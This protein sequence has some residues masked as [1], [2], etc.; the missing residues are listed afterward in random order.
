MHVI[1]HGGTTVFF[2]SGPV[3]PSHVL[4]HN[5]APPPLRDGVHSTLNVGELVSAS[6]DL[7]GRSDAVCEVSGYLLSLSSLHHDRDHVER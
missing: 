4:F 5:G 7:C 3:F 2:S 1:N 6:L